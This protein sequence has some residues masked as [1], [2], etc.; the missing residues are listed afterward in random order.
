MNAIGT[1]L[2]DIIANGPD[3]SNG[4]ANLSQDIAAVQTDASSLGCPGPN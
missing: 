3:N 1:D 2:D 4:G